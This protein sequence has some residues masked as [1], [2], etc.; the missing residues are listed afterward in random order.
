M[1]ATLRRVFRE[2]LASKV[3]EITA[4]FW[5]VKILTTAGGEAVSDYLSLG[6]KVVGGAVEFG[7]FV[8][9]LAW[10]FRTR[11]YVA[12]AYWFLAFAIAIFGCGVADLMHKGIGIPYLGTTIIWSIVLALVFLTWYRYERTLS[13]H[14]ITTQRRELFYWATVFATFAL[15]TAVGDYTATALGLGYLGS[16][17]LFGFLILM[18][19]VAWRQFHLGEVAAFWWAY[20]LTRPLGA[21]FADYVSKP[22]ARSGIAV[23]DGPTALVLTLAVVGFVAYL[24][25]TKR[26]I[27]PAIE[28]ASG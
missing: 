1:I 13:I 16:G 17:I 23:G 3:P 28:T 7:L 22:R 14:S 18:P 11:R 27:Q 2:P 9:G 26:D 5:V 20:V 6:S 25:V 10:Q 4:L 12:G 15:G 8:I 24:S 19:W 21:S